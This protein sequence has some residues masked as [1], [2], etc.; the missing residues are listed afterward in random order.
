MKKSYENIKLGLITQNMDSY[1]RQ[2][3]SMFEGIWAKLE[4]T[5]ESDFHS[6]FVL[7][8]NL[9]LKRL[10]MLGKT[11]TYCGRDYSINKTLP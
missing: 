8:G 11:F 10:H 7:F 6:I 3:G 2:H 5:Q 4:T 1:T 9:T